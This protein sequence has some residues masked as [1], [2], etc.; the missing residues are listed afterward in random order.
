MKAF[1]LKGFVFF[2]LNSSTSFY[3]YKFLFYRKKIEWEKVTDL[4]ENQVT[5]INNLNN[6]CIKED[7]LN[8]YYKVLYTPCLTNKLFIST[9]LYGHELIRYYD[10]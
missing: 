5:S 6:N 4:I 10:F 3:I 9:N 1:W 2:R 8:F 7:K